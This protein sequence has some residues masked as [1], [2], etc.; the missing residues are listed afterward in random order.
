MGE[1]EEQ[2]GVAKQ[3]L[4]ADEE[5]SLCEDADEG[6]GEKKLQDV[7][8]LLHQGP[9]LLSRITNSLSKLSIHQSS[10]QH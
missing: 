9:Q 6:Q 4:R 5:F 2:R 8:Q 1:E 10:F 3:R 7:E